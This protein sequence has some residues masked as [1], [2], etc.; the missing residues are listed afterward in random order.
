MHKGTMSSDAPRLVAHQRQHQYAEDIR[1]L[2]LQVREYPELG[3]ECK[4]LEEAI[5]GIVQPFSVAIFGRMK[6]GKSSILNAFLGQP[7]TITGVNEAT[8]TINH[9]SHGVGEQLNHFRVHWKDETPETLPLSILQERWTGK[10]DEV[11][12]TI[13]RTSYLELY[14][15]AAR[16]RDV[17]IIDTPGTGSVATEHEE[18]AQQFIGGQETD[19]LIYV[20]S[21]VGRETDEQDLRRFREGCL[22][23][24]SPYNSVALLHKW[25]ALYWDN[26]GNMDEV[27]SKAQRLE[28]VMK[29]LVA[30]VLPVSAPLAF[31]AKRAN[32]DFWEDCFSV[33]SSFAEEALLSRALSREEKWN[34]DAKQAELYQRAHSEYDMPWASFRIMLR[35]LYRMEERS[36]DICAAAL[37][38]LSGFAQ[39]EKMLDRQFFLHAGLIKQ[40]QVRARVRR[41]L[42]ALYISIERLLEE[43]QSDLS[44]LEQIDSQLS[45]PCLKGWA[46]RKI[47]SLKNTLKTMR[48]VWVDWDYKRRE[49]ADAADL[50]DKGLEARKWLDANTH[51]F[52]ETQTRQLYTILDIASGLSASE[53]LSMPELHQLNLSLSM[54]MHSHDA[55]VRYAAECLRDNLFAATQILLQPQQ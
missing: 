48:S 29:G 35:H 55:D 42:D 16:L 47:Y 11:L 30:C 22:P 33:L 18:I 9:I 38:E 14:S 44:Y 13:S 27:L 17:N 12:Q 45:D 21:P 3:H 25:D 54:Q 34:R 32:A 49:I 37:A 53:R 41:A 26:G 23:S 40:R 52:S 46:Q 10:S 19:A 24:S 7:L 8:A 31:I 15:D 51:A 20:F 50:G 2:V 5:E 28:G 4:L 1:S 6:T 36:H 43:N 39:L